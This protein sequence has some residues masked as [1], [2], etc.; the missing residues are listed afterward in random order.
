MIPRRS[1]F[2]LGQVLS[3][4]TPNFATTKRNSPNR[5]IGFNGSPTILIYGRWPSGNYK[6]QGCKTYTSLALALMGIRLIHRTGAIKRPTVAPP[7]VDCNPSPIGDLCTSPFE[8]NAITLARK[9]LSKIAAR[10]RLGMR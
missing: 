8:A 9:D 6:R 2:G 7:F 3:Q 4:S 5:C 1:L 10:K